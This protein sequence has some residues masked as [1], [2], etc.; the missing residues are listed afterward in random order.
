MD[1]L[2]MPPGVVKKAARLFVTKED[3]MKLFGC[4]KS[5]ASSIVRD[6]TKYAKEMGK[7]PLPAGRANIYIFADIYNFPIEEVNRVINEE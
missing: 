4:Q 6:V 1:D 7:C 2:V 3:G 5:K